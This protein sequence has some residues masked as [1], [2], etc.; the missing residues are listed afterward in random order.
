MPV[1][2]LHALADAVWKA[3]DA[4]CDRVG[5]NRVPMPPLPRDANEIAPPS[6]AATFPVLRYF[7][8]AVEAAQGFGLAALAEALRASRRALIW[9]QNPSYRE[10]TVGRHFVDNYA[11]GLL[12]GPE[13]PLVCEVPYGGFILLGPGLHYP[14][15]SHASREIYLVLTPG[16]RWRLDA[17]EWFDVAPGDLIYHA[18]WQ[19]HATQV[20]AQPFLAFVAWLDAARRDDA[21][22]F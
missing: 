20:G 19:R 14:D 8:D 11:Y 10:S 15:H 9:S 2:P 18:S 6:P 21:I 13:G 17:G 7:D 4:R 22:E 5:G 3:V 16:A 12:T 1:T